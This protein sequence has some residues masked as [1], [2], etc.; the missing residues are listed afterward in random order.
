MSSADEDAAKVAPLHFEDDDDV[1][2]AFSSS[3]APASR[4]KQQQ[5]CPPAV[6][7]SSLLVAIAVLSMAL[8]HL[9]DGTLRLPSSSGA[10]FTRETLV[11]GRRGSFFVIGD[12]G[13]D[14]EVHAIGSDRCQRAIAE[15]M[16]E[17]MR[18]LGDVKFVINLGDSFYPTGVQS[19]SDWQWDVKWRNV[20]SKEL[21]SIPWYSVYGNHDYYW[22]PCACDRQACAQLNS[23]I[24]NLDFFYMPDLTWFKS[25]PELDLEVIAM[26]LNMYVEGWEASYME[27]LEEGVCIT[28]KCKNR[29]WDSFKG[30]AEESFQLFYSRMERS[31]AKNLLVFSHYPTDYFVRLP[32]FLSSLSNAS[33]HHVEY[34]GG[35]RH[36]VSDTTT[37]S[38]A[39]NHNWLVGGGGGWGCD[40]PFQGFVVGEI[41]M[42]GVLRTYEVL[43]DGCCTF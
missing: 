15:R 4:A 6:C 26:D 17:K 39:P 3:A 23:N 31:L 18:E 7:I 2:S 13:W 9:S 5:R 42:N 30:R 10:E 11:T 20:Y 32:G 8:G 12:W 40:G 16:T 37:A 35:H 36:S 1:T 14:Y 24:S 43:V 21:R 28:G 41:A 33:R 25:H 22:D 27:D 34:F 29:C 19:K 38:T